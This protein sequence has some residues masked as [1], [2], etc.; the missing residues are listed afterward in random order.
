MRDTN[1]GDEPAAVTEFLEDYNITSQFETGLD[2]V[3][4]Q[5][6]GMEIHSLEYGCGDYEFDLLD[7]MDGKAAV[8][9][10]S[11]VDFSAVLFFQT[12]WGY[13]CRSWVEDCWSA[14]SSSWKS[15][16]A[17]VTRSCHPTNDVSN[18][19]VCIGASSREPATTGS[20]A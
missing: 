16:R 13:Y 11:S 1:L 7:D 18:Q 15:Q 10:P 19:D 2:R 14:L 5:S 9:Y 12:G 4:V 17:R 20:L 6:L 8:F 3:H